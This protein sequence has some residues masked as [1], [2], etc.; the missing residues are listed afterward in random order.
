MRN[1][2]SAFLVGSLLLVNVANASD[3]EVTA[4]SVVTAMLDLS[5][6]NV[7]RGSSWHIPLYETG[8]VQYFS[9][10]VGIEERQVRYP[11]FPLK[12]IFVEGKRA[13]T[14]GVAIT[15][16]N[17]KE[18]V[19]VSIPEKHVLGPWVF[20]K[21]PPGTY[22]VTA[23]YLKNDKLKRRVTIHEKKPSTVYFRWPQ[24]STLNERSRVKSKI[25]AGHV[26]PIKNGLPITIK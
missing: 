6:P 8:S 3:L 13:Y 4:P 2:W 12:L 15:I 1:V 26:E 16:T 21:A 14:T 11:A 9:A 17:H 23:T 19:I 20:V 7:Y 10:G 25:K 18:S 5:I 22:T 24:Q